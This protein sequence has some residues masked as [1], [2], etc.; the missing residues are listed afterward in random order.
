MANDLAIGLKIRD[1]K[2][3]DVQCLSDNSAISYAIANDIGFENIF[4]TQIKDIIKPE[5]ILIAI[6]CSGNSTNIIN[7]V[8]YAKNQKSKIIGLTG[9]DG[10]RL[11]EL[12]DIK[13]HIQ[14]QKNEYGLV[15]DI[16]LILNHIL[17][18]YFQ[19]S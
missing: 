18:S 6:S 17:F 3:L 13:L 1:K 5:D 11:K 9:F 15:E 16:H 8:E 19:R 4:Y 14:T 12:S 7:A 10:G 2:V